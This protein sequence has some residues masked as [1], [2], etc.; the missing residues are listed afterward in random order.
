MAKLPRSRRPQ[1][2]AG[3]RSGGGG[4]AAGMLGNLGLGD[5]E[6]EW[7]F[8]F[9]WKVMKSNPGDCATIAVSIPLLL[10]I[11]PP[12]RP[13]GLAVTYPSHNTTSTD[14]PGSARFT[15]GPMDVLLL[16]FVAGCSYAVHELVRDL[17]LRRASKLLAVDRYQ[18]ATW[19]FTACD[20]LAHVLNVIF[21]VQSLTAAP[22]ETMTRNGEDGS[23]GDEEAN[24]SWQE[25]LT[26]DFP[27]SMTFGTKMIL[28][29]NIAYFAF[30]AQLVNV[31]RHLQMTKK[32]PLETARFIVPL[33]H[34]LA[35]VV[36]YTFL[37]NRL[38]MVVLFLHHLVLAVVDTSA[39]LFPFACKQRGSD[40]PN[41][42][43]SQSSFGVADLIRLIVKWTPVLRAFLLLSIAAITAATLFVLLPAADS[44]SLLAS[45]AVRACVFA[46]FVLSAASPIVAPLALRTHAHTHAESRGADVDELTTAPA[47]AKKTNK[48]KKQA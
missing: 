42:F 47:A 23:G 27:H 14:E 31:Q 48:A 19:M 11:L 33:T 46:A 20:A 40:M 1:R 8:A 37:Y 41:W 44:P 24:L 29:T 9:F 38:A 18:Q 10:C 7:S 32:K 5:L 4:G 45:T 16:L 34:A 26:V 21:I 30:S 13:L 6:F 17:V 25:W 12:T 39:V 15:T 22:K 36:A 43:K 2:P 3:S 28:L 35:F